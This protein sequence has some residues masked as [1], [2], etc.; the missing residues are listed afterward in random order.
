[1]VGRMP[2]PWSVQQAPVSHSRWVGRRGPAPHGWHATR[3]VW[4]ARRTRR[5]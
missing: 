3:V 1:V 5:A 4:W 2:G